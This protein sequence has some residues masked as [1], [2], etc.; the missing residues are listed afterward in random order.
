MKMERPRTYIGKIFFATILL[1]VASVMPA[2]AQNKQPF[3]SWFKYSRDIDKSWLIKGGVE[4]PLELSIE[5]K[6][7][8]L[9]GPVRRIVVLY[10][11]ASSAY[12]V[13]ITE[14]LRV[15]NNKEIKA[16][17]TVINFELKDESGAKA[18]KFAE[19][20][21]FDL[22]FA[23]GS[24]STAW[25]FKH[26]YKGAIPVVT[27]CSKDPVQLGQIKDY[28]HGSGNNFAFTSL[29]VPVDVQMAYV[30][31]LR[32]DLKNIAVLVDVKNVS[33]V[34][35]QAK[36][37]ADYVSKKGGNVI[38]GS[39][40]NPA[41][42]RQELTKIIPDA[43]KTMQKTDPDLSKSLFWVTGSTSVFREIAVINQ[44]AGRVP[45]VSVVPEIVTTG[46]DTAVVAIGVGFESNASLA[47]IYGAKILDGTKAGD[48][49]V[50][51]VS[52]PDIAISF[53]K[54]H[55]IGM[56]VPFSFFEIA[57]FVYDY[58]GRA[59]RSITHALEN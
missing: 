39:V 29:N 19:E 30:R 2:L 53:M 26:Y 55:A 7:T 27:V 49:K 41:T 18:I 17:F 36:P 38:W 10:P 52:P 57:S 11:R 45:V 15:F 1:V 37:I 54:A 58:D 43:V 25:L 31:E 21:K 8:E 13:A 34:E 33:A 47:A 3:E 6:S 23:M 51:L 9:Q 50:G 46:A 42:A 24:E 4:T 14:I 16:Q 48:L 35:T 59:V 32:P 5:P 22:I 20:N 56:R 28:D 44:Y 40:Q 12:D